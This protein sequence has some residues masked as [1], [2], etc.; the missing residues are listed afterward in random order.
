[1]LL[2]TA[3]LPFRLKVLNDP[4]LFTRRDAGVVYVRRTDYRVAAELLGRVYA[5][6]SIHLR[7][8]TPVFT[9]P[10]APG[11]GLAEDPG[12]GESFGR[13]RCHL[14]ADGLII[15]SE[16][17]KKALGLR[18]Q[19]VADRFAG[20]GI[21]LAEPFL[22]PGSVDDYEFILQSPCRFESAR[23][24]KVEPGA[25]Y[26]TG[27]FLGTANELGWRL[28][29]EAVW[30]GDQ[31]N[32]LGAEPAT[33]GTGD[34]DFGVA[35]G[36]LGPAVYSGTSGV[37]LFLAE[38]HAASGGAEARRTGLGAIRHALSRADA[39]LGNHRLGLYTG[40]LGI[41][42]A[43]VRVATVL[44]EEE[45]LERA[46]KF[47]H[48]CVRERRG[49]GEFDLLSGDA[50]AIVAIMLL[51]EML[52]D[53]S[54][55]ELAVSLGD[56]LLRNADDSVAGYSWTSPSLHYRHNLTGFSHG[57]AGVAYALLELLRA[58]RDVKYWAAAVR[59]FDYER[60]W[61]SADRGNWADLRERGRRSKQQL[62]NSAF[63]TYWCHG[64]P[65]IAVARLRAY[66]I[67]KDGSCKDE[68]SIGLNTTYESTKQI[69]H[70]G[71]PNFSLCHGLLGNA[72]VLLYGS[73]VLGQEWTGKARLILEVAKAGIEISTR[74]GGAW[75]CGID[76]TATPGLLL[77]L[78]GIGYFYLRLC[79]P[80]IPSA[81]IL[82]P[83]DFARAPFGGNREAESLGFLAD[84]H[85]TAGDTL[86][87]RRPV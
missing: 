27:V 23:E 80:S 46:A 74:R 32:W 53:D 64:A 38:L 67:L 5:E 58:T 35:H 6:V 24:S 48:K 82:R 11:V 20:E 21:N 10:L 43:A 69:V 41:I 37:A 8:G 76:G 57:T 18:L 33:G 61:F 66:E 15:A 50:G 62:L 31:C 68:A 84:E 78:A 3:G 71:N 13:N 49:G 65:G 36:P 9:K 83:E 42:V 30:L 72:E 26:E 85:F 28:S 40:V 87:R 51:R 75:T 16:Q 59:A 55:L 70:T 7:P 39:L 45:L 19:T 79:N 44:G 14:L 34:D 1:M 29:Q 86:M 56:G 77:G 52:A 54:L 63:S 2:N 4:A 17:G 12:G 22:N 81:L 73:Q 47:L 25:K 60:S